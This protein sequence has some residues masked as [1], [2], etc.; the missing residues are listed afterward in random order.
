MTVHP[1][2]QC[3]TDWN[4]DGNPS[5]TYGDFILMNELKVALFFVSKFIFFAIFFSSMHPDRVWWFWFKKK[6]LLL[7]RRR[8]VNC[9]HF[10][11]QMLRTLCSPKTHRPT[12]S[13]SKVI[14]SHFGGGNHHS[15]KTCNTRDRG[16]YLG[17][18][19]FLE[20]CPN[21][22]SRTSLGGMKKEASKNWL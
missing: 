19:D 16:R 9:A 15:I 6:I 17:S 11:C 4:K 5:L 13:S 1:V 7:W 12:S 10:P 21:P 18:W 3:S 14:M 22:R 8:L 2:I 20:G